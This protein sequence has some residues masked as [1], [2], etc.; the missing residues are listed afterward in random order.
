MDLRLRLGARVA[1]GVALGVALLLGVVGRG[2]ARTADAPTVSIAAPASAVAEGGMAV[3]P[4]T[5][6]A[7][8]GNDFTVD[9]TVDD[10][11]NALPGGTLTIGGGDTSSSIS[12]PIPDDGQPNG[13]TTL[14]VTLG[15]PAWVDTGDSDPAPTVAQGQAQVTVVDHDWTIGAIQ[16]APGNAT[17]SESGSNTIDFT[18]SLNAAAVAGHAVTV[19]YAVANGS[20]QLGKNFSITQP[21][22]GHATGTITF[23]PGQSTADVQVTSI[24]DAVYNGPLQLS[25]TFSNPQGATFSGGS[26]QAMGTITNAESA[27]FVGIAACS[28]GTVTGGGVATFPVTLAASPA[29]KLPASIDYTTVADTANSGD[30]TSASGTITIPAGQREFDLNVQ[31]LVNS[32]A[33]NRTFH[34]AL[35]NPQDA[36]LDN[37]AASASCTIQ[38]TK[39]G[40]ATGL[41]SVLITDPQAVTSPA[42]GSTPVSVALTLQQPT[43]LPTSPAPVTVQWTTQDGTAKA[44]ID[45]TAASGSVTWPAGGT[46]PNPTPI[47]INVKSDPALTGPVSFT[48]VFTTDDATLS[49]DGTATVTIVPQGSTV[50]LLSI[51]NAS[52]PSKSGS[53]NVPVTLNPAASG[54]VTVGYATSDGTAQAGANYTAT[55]GTLTFAAGQK[56]Q[57]ISV[58]ITANT[59][60]SPDRDFTVMLSNATGGAVLGNASADVTIVNDFGATV[61]PPVITIPKKPLVHPTQQPATQPPASSN[62]THYVLVQVRTGTAQFDAKGH[63]QIMVSCPSVAAKTCTGTA[64]FDVRVKQTVV[65][66]KKKATVLKTVRVANGSFALVSGKTSKFTAKLTTTGAKLL[67]LYK[68]IQVKATLTSKDASGAKGVTAWL[69]TF[70]APKTPAK[71]KVAAKPKKKTPKK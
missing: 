63:A 53:V 28:G 50:P 10:N 68:Q 17:V 58:P 62:Q 23:A 25:V 57:T 26:E 15:T 37:T 31:T 38:E 12:V 21:A 52:A 3:F 1:L 32:P 39:K 48:V 35:S 42:S 14:T 16:T 69:V 45:Y 71:P 64:A 20:A 22:S 70:Q 8:A 65:K 6:S 18:V 46:G 34:V 27:P 54:V 29:T 60:S 49:G 51:A 44:G 11:G 7:A 9:Y 13:D 33:G 4:V 2:A 36:R 59:Q 41:P 55:S 47:T 56:S 19:D 24:D 66:G 30:F 43:P 67:A 40:G 5:V 61:S